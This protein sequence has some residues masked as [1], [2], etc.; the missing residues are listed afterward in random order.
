MTHA[1]GS[2]LPDWP[3]QLS[4]PPPPP[5]GPFDSSA[6]IWGKQMAGRRGQTQHETS[7]AVIS[8]ERLEDLIDGP[9]PAGPAL[10]MANC[11]TPQRAVSMSQG[12]LIGIDPKK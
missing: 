7:F 12:L 9:L 10:N 2:K 1:R 6:L 5:S 11:C 3:L 8:V 4:Q